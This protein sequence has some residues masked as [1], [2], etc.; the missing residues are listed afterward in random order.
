MPSSP[1]ARAE[2]QRLR[3]L[4]EKLRTAAIF[5][6]IEEVP[7]A[8]FGID[9]KGCHVAIDTNGKRVPLSM[10]TMTSTVEV[11]ATKPPRLYSPKGI[12]RE[13]WE[14]N[15]AS[16][17]EKGSPHAVILSQVTKMHENATGE[18]KKIAARF[19]KLIQ[20]IPDAPDWADRLP[21]WTEQ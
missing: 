1:E 21:E 5:Q 9:S 20:S 6:G 19:L 15:V 16:I 10:S 17:R 13:Q 2:Q 12:S 4:R 8:F 14:A 18:K 7:L 11:P 3:R